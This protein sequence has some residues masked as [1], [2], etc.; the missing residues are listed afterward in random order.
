VTPDWEATDTAEDETPI[1]STN[2]NIAVV[3]HWTMDK[4]AHLETNLDDTTA[5]SLAFAVQ[6]FSDTG[7]LDA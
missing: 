7:A 2:Q 5:K 6:I 4:H 3:P 1:K